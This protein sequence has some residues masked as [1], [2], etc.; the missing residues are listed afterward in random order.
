[1]F[2]SKLNFLLAGIPLIIVGYLV[3]YN[4]VW[5]YKLPPSNTSKKIGYF[6]VMILAVGLL[7]VIPFFVTY[8]KPIIV[9]VSIVGMIIGIVMLTIYL[10]NNR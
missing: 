7:L 6:G 10:K 1:M 9:I 2:E 5:K 3:A 8:I 4:F